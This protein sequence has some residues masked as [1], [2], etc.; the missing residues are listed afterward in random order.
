MT[1]AEAIAVQAAINQIDAM[2]GTSASPSQSIY[3]HTVAFVLQRMLQKGRICVDRTPDADFAG[4]CRHDGCGTR[5]DRINIAADFIGTT[6]PVF[7]QMIAVLVH[8]C[9]HALQWTTSAGHPDSTVAGAEWKA[10]AQEKDILK[11]RKKNVAMTADQKKGVQDRLNVVCSWMDHYC[12]ITKPK[13]TAKVENAA[14]GKT[15]KSKKKPELR[16]ASTYP[17]SDMIQIID[18]TTNTSVRLLDTGFDHPTDMRV[19]SS[20]AGDD[21]LYIL[22]TDS[23]LLLGGVSTLT[24]LDADGLL[25]QASL[26]FVA[27]PASLGLPLSAAPH[28]PTGAL[29]ILDMDAAGSQN[30]RILRD[31]G[32]DGL[33]DTLDPLI[34]A[35]ASAFPEL[36]EAWTIRVEGPHQLLLSPRRH[37][38]DY[39]N[40]YLVY[41][42]LFDIDQDGMADSLTSSPYNDTLEPMAPAFLTDAQDLDSFVTMDATLGS[43][44]EVWKTDASGSTL[45]ELL[46]S[47]VGSSPNLI[48]TVPLSRPVVQGEFLKALDTTNS[49][50]ANEPETVIAPRPEVLGIDLEE[51]LPGET[52]TLGGRNFGGSPAVFC[53]DVQAQVLFAS[54]NMIQFVAPQLFQFPTGNAVIQVQNVLGSSDPIGLY[55][56]EDCNNNGIGDIHDIMNG[57]SADTNG[58]SIPDECECLPGP[59]AYC[60][61]KVNSCGGTP[62]ISTHGLSSASQPSGFFIKGSQ[63]RF[64]KFGLLLYTR[65]GPA[66]QPFQG[67]TLCLFPQGIRRGPA[68]Q[69]IGGTGG[70]CESAFVLDMNAFAAGLAGGN[71][72]GYLSIP[73]QQIN[74]QW[75]GRDTIAN[76][77]YLSDAAQYTVCQ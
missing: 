32:A 36:D 45:L 41:H 61:G 75:W 22:G 31:T 70:N 25:D 10:Y 3:L 21:V 50:E 15:K 68:T 60:T 53:N 27:A 33:P 29:W 69:A 58:N 46:G 8:E 51:A 5:D 44:I 52:V 40:Q 35:H 65:F 55:V 1:G 76:G 24:D 12:A 18:T 26:A 34:F 38:M 72:A 56:H 49:L 48:N 37:G 39:G 47:T 14:A 6:E 67:G 57:T 20:P 73:G 17:P 16:Y 19:F 63:S 64:A 43:T 7:T 74:V 13:K 23:T 30:V 59:V 11:R 42:V 66:G 71:P 4:I 28:D 54:N 62:A 77:S 9:T 2:A